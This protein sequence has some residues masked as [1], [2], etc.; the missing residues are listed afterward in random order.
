MKELG[1]VLLMDFFTRHTSLI[2]SA[3]SSFTVCR[4]ICDEDCATVPETDQEMGGLGLNE[5][6]IGLYYS[7]YGAAAF[8]LEFFAGRILYC[9]RGLKKN[10]FLVVL[11]FQPSFYG[12]CVL[13]SSRKVVG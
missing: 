3:S 4:R 8:V 5:K 6:E 10:D 2:I 11:Y 9:R 7:T 12:V 1:Q 13:T